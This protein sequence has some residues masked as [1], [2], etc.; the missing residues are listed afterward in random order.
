V[1]LYALEVI[2]KPIES[3]PNFSKDNR[4]PTPLFNKCER[5]PFIH[6]PIGK[7]AQKSVKGFS[8]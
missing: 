7:R 6:Q 1:Y 5:I 8:Q 4:V 3:S 2:Q